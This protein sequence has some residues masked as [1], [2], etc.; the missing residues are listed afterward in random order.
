[1]DASTADLPVNARTAHSVDAAN[2]LPP[3]GKMV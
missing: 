3:G 2:R 1:M